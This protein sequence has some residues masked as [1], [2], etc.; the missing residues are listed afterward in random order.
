MALVM[1]RVAFCTFMQK[2]PI[3]GDDVLWGGVGNDAL[4][5]DAA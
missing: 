4:F 2:N 1:I 5:G 3:G